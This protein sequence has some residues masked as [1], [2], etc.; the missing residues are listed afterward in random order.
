M[1][2]VHARVLRD[3]VSFVLSE[4]GESSRAR[5]QRRAQHEYGQDPSCKWLRRDHAAT[6]ILRIR[7]IK[8]FRSRYGKPRPGDH[9]TLAAFN[10]FLSAS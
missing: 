9:G 5:A 4:I 3:L 1:I 7:S 2:A 10:A 8:G 6:I